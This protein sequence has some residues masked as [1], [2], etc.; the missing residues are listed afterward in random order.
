MIER[1][2]PPSGA[3]EEKPGIVNSWIRMKLR[4]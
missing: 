2:T 4:P 1:G 3:G